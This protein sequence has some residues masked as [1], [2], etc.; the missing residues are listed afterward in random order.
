LSFTSIPFHIFF[1]LVYPPGG[2]EGESV[3][4]SMWSKL[5]V[6]TFQKFDVLTGSVDSF[7]LVKVVDVFWCG[8]P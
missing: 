8:N 5:P 7:V 3:E 1:F 4:S 6:I 2:V